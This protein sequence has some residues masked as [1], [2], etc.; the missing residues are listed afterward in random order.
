MPVRVGWNAFH[1]GP[2]HEERLQHAFVH[3]RHPLSGDALIVEPV[4]AVE[5]DGA[6][7][8]LRR[9]VDDRDEERQDGLSD[10]SLEGVPVLVVVLPLALQAMAHGLVEQHPGRLRLEQRGPGVGVKHRRFLQREQLTH[11]GVD[12]RGQLRPSGQLT[13]ERPI[14]VAAILQQH[15][16]R[17][18]RPSLHV[19]GVD[20]ALD[21]Q[22]RPFRAGELALLVIHR[23]AHL[24]VE[25]LRVRAQPLR[26]LAQL[27]PPHRAVERERQRRID[28][29]AR[30]LAREAGGR[31]RI[32]RPVHL[33][34]LLLQER[35]ERFLVGLVG[36]EPESVAERGGVVV[37][38][39][40]P[41]GGVARVRA[42][43]LERL[44]GPGVVELVA[45]DAHVHLKALVAP[46]AVE[47]HR[48]VFRPD[49]L[50]LDAAHGVAEEIRSIV[51]AQ[52][53]ALVRAQELFGH[54]GQLQLA[55]VLGIRV[56]S[57]RG[58]Q[59][60]GEHAPVVTLSGR[61]LGEKGRGGRPESAC[62][63]PALVEG[64]YAVWTLSRP[65]V[66]FLVALRVSITSLAS[67]TSCW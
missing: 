59:Q 12:A 41:T 10:L 11:H 19:Q 54:R 32:V 31:A 53:E 5:R 43:E 45:P 17:R 13:L 18:P 14:K 2:R 49:L 25:Q 9:V 21:D 26:L 67:R 66:T 22:T 35:G 27:A 39:R 6:C 33:L 3:Q 48:P 7:H 50:R 65:K 44:L 62:P 34:A 46:P 16:V 55:G 58:R 1:G 29:H 4:V 61:A 30:L 57:D 36:E 20:D 38:R 15:A 23:N 64:P 37:E 56:E 52:L 8:P 40:F 63:R 28:R 47:E 42:V 60:Q 24:R 51:A